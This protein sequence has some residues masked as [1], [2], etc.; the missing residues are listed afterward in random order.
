MQETVH[1]VFGFQ[2]F[3]DK[4]CNLLLFKGKPLI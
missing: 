4:T 1:C 2:P 3:Q